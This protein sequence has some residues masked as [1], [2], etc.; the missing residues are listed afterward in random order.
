MPDSKAIQNL[1]IAMNILLIKDVY[2]KKNCG[3]GADASIL[4]GV[5]VDENA[6]VGAA[7]VVKDIPDHCVAVGNSAQVISN[8][9]V[10]CRPIQIRR[11]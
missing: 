9:N 8:Q 6:I 7:S 4:P 10:G 1:P 3:I 11:E 2:L 5:T